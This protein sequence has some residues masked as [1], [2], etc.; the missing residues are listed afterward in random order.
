MK[1]LLL[2]FFLF[3][4]LFINNCSKN[5]K[6]EILNIEEDQIEGQM[7]RAYQEGMVAFEM[8]RRESIDIDEPYDLELAEWLLRE[9]NGKEVGGN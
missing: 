6:V 1:K 3:G 5:K 8:S 4:F 7:I 2:I 9:R